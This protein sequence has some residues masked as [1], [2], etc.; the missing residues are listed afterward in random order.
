MREEWRADKDFP[1][2]EVSNYGRVRSFNDYHRTGIGRI[3]T[4]WATLSGYRVVHLC[5]GEDRRKVQTVGRMVLM[6]FDPRSNMDELQ[7]NH[8][9]LNKLNNHLSNLEWCSPS[10]NIKHAY[11]AGARAPNH[12]EKCSLSKLTEKEVIEMRDMKSK[13]QKI[14]NLE[15]AKLFNTTPTNV[16]KIILRKRWKHI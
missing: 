12:G 10:G 16:S 1:K 14:S 3:M 8:K 9:D 2:Y 11:R 6:A 4:G 7:C 15:L 5:D 13:N